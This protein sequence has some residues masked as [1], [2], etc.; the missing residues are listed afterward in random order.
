MLRRLLL[1]FGILLFTVFGNCEQAT[2]HSVH[3]DRIQKVEQDDPAPNAV[4]SDLTTL[5]RICNAR[6]QRVLPHFCATNTLNTKQYS[7]KST[8]LQH[9]FT[10]FHGIERSESAPI[11]F[12]VASKYYIICLRHLLC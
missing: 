10:T 7:Y 2:A 4:L 5:Y 11:H 8:F 6:P 1:I 9:F 12:D 3:R